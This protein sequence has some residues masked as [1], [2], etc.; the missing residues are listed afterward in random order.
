MCGITA[1]WGEADSAAIGEMTDR[2][3]H[4][5]PDGR[6]VRIHPSEPAALGHTRLAVI[7]LK[8][9][10]QPIA[11]RRGDRSII[12][13]GEIYNYKRLREELDPATFTTRSDTEVILRL[14]ERDGEDAVAQLDGMFAFVI[15]DGQNL[16]AAR[17]PIG[18]KPLYYGRRGAGYAFASEIKALIGFAEDIREFPPGHT[19]HSA[20]GFL[21][22]YRIP[23]P[24]P[25]ET[26]E[27]RATSR[28]IAELRETLERAV[29]KWMV[30]DVP[31]GAFLSGGLDSS[32]IAAI[33]RRHSVELHTFAV[34]IEG[35]GD[36]AAAR[37]V[38]RHIGS[39]HH[40]RVFS[41]GDIV[42]ALPSIIYHLES[43]DIDLV[44][45]AI[46]CHFASKLASEHLKV[47]LTGEGADELFA[48]YAYYRDYRDE[49]VLAEELTRSIAAMHN[50]NLQR[51][52]RLTMAHGLEGRVPFLDSEMIAFA[53]QIPV[54]LKLRGAV[55]GPR[56]EKWILR[57]AAS[58][59]LPHDIVWR[60]KLQFD[61]GSGTVDTL[62]EVLRRLAGTSNGGTDRAAERRLY[63]RLLIETYEDPGPVFANAGSW[64]VDRVQT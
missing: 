2:L 45:S 44:R 47:V 14:Y 23:E 32:L 49:A 61:E 59:L 17:D 51:V 9:G 10:D 43:D 22:Y 6:R 12:A 3:R 28:L 24:A 52:D 60:E 29:E 58:G 50:I 37:R 27:T 55:A 5:G 4:R 20:R 15:Q 35:S 57:A 11:S 53:Q 18:I 34:G 30:S 21:R 8:G 63:R 7:D 62:P 41:P 26:P 36:M 56:V 48:G 13:N 19:F 39:V 16:F 25:P 31:V 54:S 33:A 46:P 40:E 38:A 1:L 42:E 64:A